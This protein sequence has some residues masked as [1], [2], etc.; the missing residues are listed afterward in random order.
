MAKRYIPDPDAEFDEWIKNFV[1]QASQIGAQVGIP[2]SELDALDDAFNIW[3]VKYP[4][5]TVAKNAAQAA[6]QEKDGARDDVESVARRVTGQF[7]TNPQVTDAQREILGITVRDT[8][9]TPLSPDY[10]QTL[11]TPLI[12]VDFS[13]PCRAII[14]V[15]TNPGDERNNAKPEHIAG[16]KIWLHLVNPSVNEAKAKNL[17][18]FL[19]QLDYQEWHEWNFVADATNSPY[20]HI[21]ETQVPITL[22]YKAQW[23]DSK[24][25]LGPLGEAVRVTISP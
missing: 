14:H 13:Q 24:M 3:D 2:Q 23:F 19:E 20:V 11:Q 12:I 1:N 21:I 16:V 17:S 22:D 8:E 6:K 18:K 4:A 5:H 7:Q 9:P 10:V 25:R 15:G